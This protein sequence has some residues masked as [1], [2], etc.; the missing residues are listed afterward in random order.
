MSRRWS[1]TLLLGLLLG[2][3]FAG[4]AP[5]ANA[6]DPAP[7]TFAGTSPV[8]LT[9]EKATTRIRN[10]TNDERIV[11]VFLQVTSGKSGDLDLVTTSLRL[12]PRESAE[13]KLVVWRG[14]K[15]AKFSGDIVAVD[16]TG[17]VARQSFELK[18]GPAA[19]P[20]MESITDRVTVRPRSTSTED[21]DLMALPLGEGICKPQEVGLVGPDDYATLVATCAN[22]SKLHLNVTDMDK[23][24]AGDYE[25][26]LTVGE[27]D[28]TVKVTRSAPIWL[29]LLLLCLGIFAAVW[30][31]SYTAR[32]PLVRLQDE[33]AELGK[34]AL[35][36]PS[37]WTDDVEE[38][39][40]AEWSRAP[41][42]DAL[43]MRAALDE[44]SGWG[45]WRK[46]FSWLLMP[47]TKTSEAITEQR[48]LYDAAVAT[49]DSWDE[50]REK[51]AGLRVASPP[52]RRKRSEL[53]TAGDGRAF[54]S[55]DD[56]KPRVGMTGIQGLLDEVAA[57]E[58]D[59]KVW[60]RLI[61]LREDIGDSPPTGRS[62]DL[63][64][65]LSRTWSRC[66]M[67]LAALQQSIH[68]QPATPG[69]AERNAKKA[70]AL[71]LEARELKA[72]AGVTLINLPMGWYVLRP[73]GIAD[74]LASLALP[75]GLGKFLSSAKR[76]FV[77]SGGQLGGLVVTLLAVVIVLATG[78]ATL[79][80]GKAWGT[81]WDMLAAFVA[82]ASG[83]LALTPLLAA[84][85]QISGVTTEKSEA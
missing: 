62:G 31:R 4:L 33:I 17:F 76:F 28:V 67:K 72:S 22:D 15:E 10:E 13:V 37:S 9:P 26:T 40:P 12:A 55:L 3:L 23:W 66:H 24:S 36:P 56:E 85:D 64:A 69:R 53:I 42:V 35:E 73:V 14:S 52:A 82:G 71:E 47:S 25:G 29:F 58:S 50:T 39:R 78:L 32:R 74:P 80:V 16:Q 48:K 6:D 20:E 1:A 2:L 77:R 44:S 83:T 79:Y 68:D 38:P 30:T 49:A 45:P 34:R 57:L 65:A 75:S 11:G 27:T 46:R 54:L 59:A 84:L 43:K 5:A 18:P 60:K 8:A 70:E 41:S 19:E 81:G 61:D 7:I 63:D 21:G 51:I